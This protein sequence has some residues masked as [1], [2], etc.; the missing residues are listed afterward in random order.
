LAQPSYNI[1]GLKFLIVD[2]SQNMSNLVKGVLVALG[3]EHFNIKVATDGADALKELRHFV[4]D[5]AICDWNMEPLDGIE[6]TKMVR[7][8]NDSANPFLP[9]IMLTGHTEMNRIVEARD[10]G[11]HEYLAKPISAKSLYSRI[12]SIIDRPRPFVKTSGM[13]AY[14]GPDRRRKDNPAYRGPERRKA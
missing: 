12:S 4:P 1:Q 8:S 13:N 10:A 3:V 9:I 14:F 7:T 6:F 2:D 5:I 11:I